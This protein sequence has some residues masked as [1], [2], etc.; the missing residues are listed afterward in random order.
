MVP[1]FISIEVQDIEELYEIELECFGKDAFPLLEYQRLLYSSESIPIKAA[2]EG[3]IIGFVI[4]VYERSIEICTVVTLNIKPGFRK[5]GIGFELMKS[6]EDRLGTMKCKEIILQTRVNNT[7]GL[8][9]FDKLGFRIT[10][11]LLNYYPNGIDGFEMK[12]SIA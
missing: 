12:K 2:V 5:Q 9:L 11:R 3:K 6:L 8:N 1:S 4:G 7:A 10:R